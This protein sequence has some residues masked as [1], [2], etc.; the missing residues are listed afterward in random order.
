MTITVRLRPQ[1]SPQINVSAGVSGLSAYE[2]AVKNGFSGT[3]QEWLASL[4][5]VTDPNDILLP[6]ELS[7]LLGGAKTLADALLW[8]A[9][10]GGAPSPIL[11]DLIGNVVISSV[12]TG[13]L[14]VE[15]ADAILLS[16]AISVT[17]SATG[18]LSVEE[19]EAVLLAGSILATSALTG[20]L[21]ADEAQAV[22]LS[23]AV[24]AT[25]SVTGDLS[26]EEGD[27]SVTVP[28]HSAM[29][30][31]YSFYRLKSGYT[32]PVA[33]VCATNAPST[34]TTTVVVT[35]DAQGKP[36]LTAAKSA[37]GDTFHIWK[38]HDQCGLSPD[39]VYSVASKRQEING[40]FP[41]YPI[42]T[43]N[44]V[45]QS[46]DLTAGPTLQRQAVSFLE[47]T[48]GA[49]QGANA[50]ATFSFGNTSDLAVSMSILSEVTGRGA[51]T[52]TFHRGARYHS[53]APSV[54][55]VVSSATA[56][57]LRAD[58]WRETLGP[59]TA[60]TMVGLRQGAGWYASDGKTTYASLVYSAALSDADEAAAWS[61]LKTIFG[62][63]TRAAMILADG[64]SIQRG[65]GSTRNLNKWAHI[66]PVLGQDV[67]VVNAAV[68]GAI[69]QARSLAYFQ[70]RRIAGLNQV[71]G[72]NWGSND[73][74][75]G[76]TA[77]TIFG[78]DNT[79]GTRANIVN[80]KSAGFKVVIET[81]IRRTNLTAAQDAERVAFNQ[82]IR[83]NA[84]ALGYRVV[85]YGETVYPTTDGTHPTN[86]GYEQMAA[87]ALSVYQAALAA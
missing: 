11:R 18:A 15:A 72:Q 13:A 34:P 29:V 22:L 65:Q 3:E 84:A 5:G 40:L 83:D 52:N 14:S 54:V 2:I 73:F 32:G 59:S 8:L 71:W 57:K 26:V 68:P 20:V 21:S 53:F 80:A 67:S 45:G 81:V 75:A 7:A 25:S 19:A 58:D 38:W 37:F 56:T 30:A 41:A 23:G 69:Q 43:F 60:A 76:R 49:M 62:V 28:D 78:S 79:S 63:P 50:N 47:V 24:A 74:A 35:T 77:A 66:A 70:A 44:E 39:L 1:G 61:A 4:Q 33:T 9:Q 51:L 64:D 17:S 55:S 12:A 48:G 6:P 46:S 85:D 82:M 10:N 86:A 87:V 27:L 36:D 16:G 31:A 42:G